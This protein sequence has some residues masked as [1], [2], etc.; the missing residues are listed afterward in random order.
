[1]ADVITRFKLETTQYDSKLR[2]ASKNLADYEKEASKAGKTF[3][4]FSKEQVEAARSFG[5]VESG[6]TSLKDKLKDLVGSYN[7]AAKAFN[8]LSDEQKN[9]DFGK[10]LSESL[11]TLQGRITQ[12]KTDLYD[13]SS[14]AKS[15][16]GIMDQLAK[17]FT[18]NIDVIKMFNVGLKAVKGA[19]DVAKDA[20]FTS[21]TNVDNWGRVVASSE[22]VY[23]SFLQALNNSNFSGFLTRIDEVIG[24]AKEAYN[25]MDELRTR[26]TI[27]NPERV[28]LQA[29]QTQLRATIRR[30]GADSEAGRA[31]QQQLRE[32]EPKLQRSFSTE[33]GLN[34]NAFTKQV[35]KKLSEAGIK[36]SEESRKALMKSFYSDDAYQRLRA[37]ARGEASKT[38]SVETPYGR[39]VRETAD[40]RNLNQKL[41]DLFTDEWRNQYSPLLSAAFSAVGQS[42]SVMLQDARYVRET[43][44]KG[45]G[46]GGGKTTTTTTTKQPETFPEGSLKSLT[47]EM[48]ELQKAQQLV[49]SA[50]EWRTYEYAIEGVKNQIKELKGE[51]PDITTGNMA[52][53]SKIQGVSVADMVTVPTAADMTKRAEKSLKNFKAP[54]QPTKQEAKLTDIMS[55]MNSGISSMVSGIE[56]LG[57]ELPKGLK[58]VLGGIQ[59]VTS[60]LTGIATVIQAIEVIS[61]ASAILPFANG[62][63]VK[64]ASGYRVPGRTFSGDMIP[65]RLNAGETVLNQAQAGVIAN[66]LQDREF[67]GV[68]S[69]QPYVEGERIY[70][71]VENTLKRKGKGEIV[72]TSMLRRLGIM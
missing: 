27:I 38:V 35:D 13:M 7:T 52:S 21:E 60:I 45:G 4:G 20:F 53:L 25:A 71:G 34:W 39:G 55:Q 31:A 33:S 29:R 40:T 1:M 16:G 61:T 8:N 47:A 44:N 48:Q 28:A 37:G 58:D 3:A 57:I 42:A 50:D 11:K 19:L 72:T 54:E 46:G 62:G 64:A 65:A 69:L 5:K 66:A 17:K 32:L 70:L 18:L 67:G 41:L 24:K 23:Q 30:E 6:A 51:L 68:A 2:E 10:A 26:M 22:S 59:S 43:N 63:V 15:T 49:T 56:G 9:S 14:S 36:L 12:T